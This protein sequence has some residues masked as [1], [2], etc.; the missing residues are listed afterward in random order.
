[1]T[2]DSK[3]APRPKKSHHFPS[4]FDQKDCELILQD[5]KTSVHKIST[6]FRK[7]FIHLQALNISLIPVK[8]RLCQQ[9]VGSYQAVETFPYCGPG[10]AT[11]LIMLQK[12]QEG[13][14][15][16]LLDVEHKKHEPAAIQ[17]L[18][19]TSDGQLDPKHVVEPQPEKVVEVSDDPDSKT[20][21]EPITATVDGCD[22][23]IP[24]S[25]TAAED[26]DSKDRVPSTS[27]RSP[28]VVT[29]M[30]VGDVMIIDK[31]VMH[32]TS[33]VITGDQIMFQGNCVAF[34][35]EE[36]VIVF[37]PTQKHY[38][39]HPRNQIPAS[40]QDEVELRACLGGSLP[41]WIVRTSFPLD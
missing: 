6:S 31:G 25:S 37:Y 34:P 24:K 35:K 23:S 7:M 2:P 9:P 32:G 13:G 12:C 20:G 11:I 19:P 22:S 21:P 26:K 18:F 8:Q 3:S 16:I 36:P 14:E 29:K 27:A 39:I 17:R 4:L 28:V 30:E 40:L 38:L 41:I 1:M 33:F 15:V 10:D 5:L